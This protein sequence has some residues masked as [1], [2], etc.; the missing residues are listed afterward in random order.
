MNWLEPGELRFSLGEGGR[1]AVSGSIGSREVAVSRLFPMTHPSAYISLRTAGGEEL[2]VLRTMDGLD[3]F[4]R[5]ALERELRLRQPLPE[6]RE[7]HRIRR[8]YRDWVW[9]V[10]TDIGPARFRTGPLYES[11]VDL[12]NGWRFVVD[13]DDQRYLMPHESQMNKASRKVLAKWL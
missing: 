8:G 12:Q 6:I 7:I 5:I 4:S 13:H 11:A 10:T 2:G 9:E 3:P 1:L